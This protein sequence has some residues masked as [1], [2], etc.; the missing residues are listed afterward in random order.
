MIPVADKPARLLLIED[1]PGDARLIREYIRDAGKGSFFVEEADRLALGLEALRGGTTDL[2]LLDLSL[3]DS[4]GLE[5]LARVRASVPA[6]PVVVLTGWSDG[7][8][9]VQAV[10]EGA[11][12]YLI[13]GEFHA[14]VLVRA[15]RYAIERKRAE[16]SL[17]ESEEK[18][19]VLVANAGEA[20]F[21]A[22]DDVV[23]FPNPRVLAL[24]GYSADE[25]ARIPFA[26]LIHP[27]DRDRA[28]KR[29]T[30]G[31]QGMLPRAAFPFRIVR[32]SGKELWVQL[33][34]DV[35]A[36][37]GRPGILCLLRD[38]TRERQLE[39]HYLRAQK[40]EAVGQL[41]GGIAHE[42]NNA[43]TGI[44]GFGG[45]LRVRLSGDDQALHDLDEIL[46]CAD[47]ASTLTRQ[48]LAF[49]RRLAIEPVN[50]SLN[51]LVADLMKL[52]AKLVGEQIDVKTNLAEGLPTVRADRGQIEQILMNLCLNARD[53]MPEGGRLL[54][55]TEEVHL[56]EEHV[57]LHP[58]I[59]AGRYVLLRVTDTGIGMDEMTR[60]R[61]FEP[62]FTTKA[63]DRGTGLGLAMVYGIV[64]QH[65][66]YIHLDSERGKGATFSVYFPA[67][68][69]T[70]DAAPRTGRTDSV[71]GGTETVLLA[72]DEESVRWLAKRVLENLG[73]KVLVARNGEEA[74][75]VFR[76]NPKVA[77]AILDV[78]M[79]RKGGKEAYEEMRKADPCLK[80]VFMSGYAAGSMDETYV[81][82]AGAPFLSKP[83]GPSSLGN[84]VR[85]VL[86]GR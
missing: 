70:P 9:G 31:I 63:P 16:E 4:H 24:T 78:I 6:V 51:A 57:K 36:W 84:K 54:V 11:Q 48:L 46:R 33:T 27:E 29:Y 2:V 43:L 68:D 82:V 10:R 72:E 23:K 59:K 37:E 22:Q 55:E 17:R 81:P 8:I 34:A 62:F 14:D 35:V 42:F 47:R 58:Y 75:D 18:Y 86:D 32:K 20:I 7:E 45:L 60:E 40:M 77:L 53:A 3:S 79:P 39:A 74:V 38:I 71:R 13:K 5:T 19:R 80:V 15:V 28:V 41:A 76:R 21:V 25:L 66:G 85:E 56:D 67:T 30:E 64:K 49:G 83:F 69:V 44:L 12:D 65:D 61:A 73:Y 26:S 52:I 1:N 50:L